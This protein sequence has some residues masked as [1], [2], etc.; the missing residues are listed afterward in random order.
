MTINIKKLEEILN[1][2]LSI[3]KRGLLIT[4]LLLK[5]S[6][7]EFTLA[8]LKSTIKIKDYYQKLQVI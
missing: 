1:D 3:K 5:D 8:K 6:K 4:I 2:N 7:P